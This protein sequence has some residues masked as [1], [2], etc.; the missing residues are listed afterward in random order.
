MYVTAI[1]RHAQNHVNH[2]GIKA[3]NVEL[4]NAFACVSKKNE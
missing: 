3:G 1:L 4:G 2:S